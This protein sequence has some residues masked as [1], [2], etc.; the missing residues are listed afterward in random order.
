MSAV[1]FL[2]QQKPDQERNQKEQALKRQ[3]AERQVK[4]T[5]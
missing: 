5:V 1:Y 2:R 3:E 4:M